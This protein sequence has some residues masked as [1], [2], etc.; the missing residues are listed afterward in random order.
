MNLSVGQWIGRLRRM[1]RPLAG[2]AVRLALP[3]ILAFLL[4]LCVKGAETADGS[5]E[6]TKEAVSL[7][8]TVK[9]SKGSAQSKL[10]DNSNKT[11]VQYKKGEV[12]TVT[13]E[14]P[15]YGIYIRWGSTVSPYTLHYNDKTEK[16]GKQ[17]FLH[18]Y[19]ELAEP[20]KSVE[21]KIEKDV[22]V[23]EIEAFSEGRLPADVQV[24]KPALT[25]ADILVFST[26]ADDEIL[27]MGGVLAQYGGQEKRRVQ[28]VYMC[29]FWSTA[30]VREHEKLDGL[31]ASGIRNY[32]VCM[33]FYD[34]YSKTLDA[35]KK[36]YDF[37]K[38]I[39]STCEMVRRFKP[40]VI[41]THDIK[42]EYGHGGH[43]ILNAAVQEVIEHSMDADYLPESAEK[44]GTWDVQKTY[45]H[46]YGKNKL[47]LNMR[48]PLSEFGGKTALEVAKEAYKK[49][50]SQQWCW[51]YVSDDYEYSA[52]E[53]GLFR[54]TVGKDTGNNMM[55]HASRKKAQ[56]TP[57]PTERPTDAVTPVVTEEPTDTV[58]PVVTEEPKPTNTPT[59]KP[60]S[61]PT[62]KPTP[63]PTSTPTPKP[64]STPT[65]KP[66]STPT[67][68][69]TNTPTPTP[70]NTPTP[71]PTSTPTPTPTNTPTPTPTNTPTPTPT[72]T[73]T[74]TPTNTPT[75][76]PTDTPV[77]TQEEKAAIGDSGIVKNKDKE[78]DPL[79]YAIP[80]CAFSA[81]AAVVA[82]LL[83][84]KAKRRKRLR[85]GAGRN[86]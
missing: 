73:P 38:L 16:H 84:G 48:V 52:A 1:L 30:H 3:V 72:N 43:M 13:S 80:V 6:E 2:P 53:F 54:T 5:K 17:G 65:P 31:W 32:P 82:G 49:H 78:V 27:F 39:K 35:A 77:P 34:H 7:K 76:I 33:N 46:L 62:P 83:R 75:P 51:F 58:T 15:M 9:N 50:E 4:V 55:E 79:L 68:T 45:F 74:P 59:P 86:K 42:G 40:L 24:W 70:T 56:V 81:T 60:T 11:R 28:V 22:Y 10:R 20:A 57:T 67:L 14:K 8:I 37:N 66:T 29:E 36:Q 12:L 44:Y 26:H 71:T 61:T 41:V 23:S 64:T 69:P 21:I 25:E 18:D 47:K 63:T 19:V 85:E